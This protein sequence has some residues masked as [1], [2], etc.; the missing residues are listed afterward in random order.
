LVASLEERLKARP[1]GAPVVAGSEEE[2]EPAPGPVSRAERVFRARA[3]RAAVLHAVGVI[4]QV[5]N[6]PHEARIVLNESRVLCEQLL[7]ERPG[8]APLR[9]TLTDTQMA[10]RSLD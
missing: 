7:G 10:L 9:A 4:Q 1:E 5:R 3:D 8:D 6:H 2:G